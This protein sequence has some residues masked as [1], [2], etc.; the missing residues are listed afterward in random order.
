MVNAPVLFKG[1]SGVIV[2]NPLGVTERPDEDDVSLRTED[3]AVD[4][5]VL[6]GADDVMAP[7]VVAETPDTS[8]V[9]EDNPVLPTV[10]SLDAAVTVETDV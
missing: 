4:A 2:E 5:L 8:K 6:P 7:V 9:N 3:R 1:M 10:E